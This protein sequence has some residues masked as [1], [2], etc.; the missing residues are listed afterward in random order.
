MAGG[1]GRTRQ[2]QGQGGKRHPKQLYGS[3]SPADFE[4]DADR[5]VVALIASLSPAVLRS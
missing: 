3:R 2:L 4:L 1:S 5:S